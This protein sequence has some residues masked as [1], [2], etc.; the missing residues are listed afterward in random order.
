MLSDLMFIR[1]GYLVLD[2]PMDEVG[3]RYTQLNARNE[4]IEAAKALN[5]V[6]QEAKFG[7]NIF[8]FDGVDKEQLAELG[9][10]TIPTVSDLFVA[11]MQRD[12]ENQGEA[13]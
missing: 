11:L 4:S 8:V 7:Q 1:D 2:S 9:E 6:Y 12:S 5:P 3:E 13:I 10:I